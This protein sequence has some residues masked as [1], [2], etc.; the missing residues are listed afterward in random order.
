MTIRKIME[1]GNKKGACITTLP[2]FQCT[3]NHIGGH[4]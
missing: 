1:M 2:I 3:P 4:C